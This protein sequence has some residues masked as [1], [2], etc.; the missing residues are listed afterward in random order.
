VDL[1][2]IIVRR[3]NR[4]FLR[5]VALPREP[6]WHSDAALLATAVLGSGSSRAAVVEVLARYSNHADLLKRLLEVLARRTRTTS[7]VSLA[8]KAMSS[9]LAGCPY[10]IACRAT[11]S[12]RS[13]AAT[14]AA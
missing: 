11:S 1:T 13:S 14:S 4:G 8:W 2:E 12:W 9:H 5:H 6:S 10:A 7:G 3:P